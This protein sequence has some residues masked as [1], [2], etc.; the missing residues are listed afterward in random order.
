MDQFAQ[1]VHLFTYI[2]TVPPKPPQF[3]NIVTLNDT[4][5]LLTWKPPV[6]PGAD[7]LTFSVYL[8]DIDSDR[9]KVLSVTETSAVI[10]S[11]FIL[12]MYI[13]YVHSFLIIYLATG[14]NNNYF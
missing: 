11:M 10:S 13:V 6:Q 7:N 12:H 2:L 1:F 5:V 8:S 9:V 14:V 3:L 4:S